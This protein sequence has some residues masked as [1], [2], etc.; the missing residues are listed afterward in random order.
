MARAFAS[1]SSLAQIVKSEFAK[2]AEHRVQMEEH[3]LVHLLI[4]DPAA[5]SVS[6]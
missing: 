4:L 1:R 6:I 5:H 3:A 2:M